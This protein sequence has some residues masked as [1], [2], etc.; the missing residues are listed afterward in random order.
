MVVL[1]IIKPPVDF[2]STIPLSV[3]PSPSLPDDGVSQERWWGEVWRQPLGAGLQRLAGEATVASG[4][5]AGVTAWHGIQ[6]GSDGLAATG[7]QWSSGSGEARWEQR[8]LWA[9]PGLRRR[10]SGYL[11]RCRLTYYGSKTDG[12][13]HFRAGSDKAL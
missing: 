13:G 12:E 2:V 3:L 1:A 4:A 10:G 9:V 11:H 6:A 8:R 5:T 7:Q